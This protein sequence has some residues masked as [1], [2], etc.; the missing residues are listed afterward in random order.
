MLTA[1]VLAIATLASPQSN[2]EARRRDWRIGPVIYQVFVDRFA[3]PV[4]P[5]AKAKLFTNPRQFM[6]WSTEPKGGHSLPQ[7]G[8]WSHELEFWGGDL[9]GIKRKLPYIQGLGADV[10]YMT[11]IF[12]AFTN[13]KYDTQDYLQVAPEFGTTADL[14]SL[15]STV[16]K[17]GM[18]IM[19]DGVFNH[20]GKTSPF[21]KAATRS[22]SPYRQ[23]FYFDKGYPSGYKGWAGV[24]N[25]PALRLENP[26][27]QRYLWGSP[28]SVV[29][30]YLNRG[31]DGW[32]LDVAF[33]L[34]DNVLEAITRSAHAAKRD[35]AVV[36]EISGYPADWFH[37]IDGVFNFYAMRIA[38][39]LA[40]GRISAPKA[41]NLLADLVQDAGIDNLLRSWLLTDNHDTPRLAS[42]V[43]DSKQRRLVQALQFTL[44]GSPVI[45]YG[46]EL[47]MKGEGDPS[48]RAPMRWDLANGSNADLAW[49]K[50]LVG[51]RKRKPAL[52]YGDF[53]AIASDSLLAFSRVTDRVRDTV[54]VVANSSNET[55]K[56]SLSTR[57]GKFMSW[58]NLRDE[59]TGQRVECVNGIA[60]IEAKPRS[61]MLLT[62]ITSGQGGWSPYDRVK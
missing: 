16:H 51:I 47:G 29:K 24:A 33:E 40:G 41:S 22:S 19:L 42:I 6:P 7:L 1:T 44:P 46:S 36:G 27:V 32:R 58:G 13:H 28:D 37:C 53:R 57:V 55:V 21:F 8:V 60:T 30:H 12:S 61:I 48:N 31:I 25:L 15:T 26:A 49:I 11:P 62:P 38:E 2:F 52:R 3:P 59:L 10:L 18:R 14:Q 5:A 17:A 20:M 23:W 39:D 54:V 4:T 45:Y 9:Q 43:P 34:G 35:S 50:K 56:E